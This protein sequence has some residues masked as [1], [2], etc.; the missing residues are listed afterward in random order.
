[1]NGYSELWLATGDF[2]PLLLQ[3]ERREIASAA[4]GWAESGLAVRIVRGR[5]MR[6]VPELFNEFAAAL[7]F[8]LYFGEN[9]DAFDECISELDGVP[10]GVGYVVL[11]TEPDQ[12][13][14]DDEANELEWLVQSLTAATRE[15]AQP[16]DRG[17]W[18]DR[19]AMP[20]HV[21]LACEGDVVERVSRVWCSAGPDPISL[22]TATAR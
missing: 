14:A 13:L 7:Q 17:E 8:P 15:W 2:C 20:F 16:V 10:T 1:M 3:G 18:W 6:S 19:P 5:K 4:A 22:G 12:V 9:K 21:V 11:I